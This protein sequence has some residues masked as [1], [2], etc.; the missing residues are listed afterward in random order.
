[1]RRDRAALDGAGDGLVDELGAVVVEEPRESRGLWTERAA[2]FDER[3]V[4]RAGAGA[5]GADSIASS[6][7]TC[8]ALLRG[9]PLEVLRM[10]D[11]VPPPVAARVARDL[12]G[13]VE[14]PDLVL[15]RDERERTA[16][17]RVRDGVLVAVEGHVGLLAA[18]HGAHE[19]ER[20]TMRGQRQEAG[21]LELEHRG[22]FLSFGIGRVRARMGDAL[23]PLPDLALEH[24]EIRYAT[25]LEEGASHVLDR[26]LDLALLVGAIRR[27]G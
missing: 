4:E 25:C 15:G 19:M 1:L 11:D 6:L 7:E 9:E 18:P 10:L 24:G 23:D 2:P 26:A 3:L 27:A 5:R 14:Q 12:G 20:R 17:E 21:A 16:H 8:A 13:A 22:D